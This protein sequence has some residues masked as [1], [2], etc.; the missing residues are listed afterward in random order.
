MTVLL[1]RRGLPRYEAPRLRN[2]VKQTALVLTGGLWQ[3][4][5]DHSSVP[6]EAVMY[7]VIR[8]FAGLRSVGAAARRAESGLGMLMKQCAGF[9]AYYI[10]DGGDGVGGSV[11]LFAL[12]HGPERQLA[13]ARRPSFRGSR[14]LPILKST[15]N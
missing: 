4:R 2:R 7:V 3:S 9:H 10:F 12:H 15:P 1:R 14:L 13:A 11:T 6:V 5:P 8:K